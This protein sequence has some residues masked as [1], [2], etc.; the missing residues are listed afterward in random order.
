MT[1]HAILDTATHGDL[2][3][4][5]IRGETEGDAVM[6]AL[7]VPEEFRRLQDCY[8]ILFRHDPANDSFTALAIFGFEPGENL[9]LENGDW[10]ARCL[11]LAIDIQPFLIG[12]DRSGK[13]LGQV[14]IDM[15]SARISRTGQGIRVFDENGAPTPYLENIA[16]QLGA[17]DAG[18]I[19]SAE[20]FAALRYH[21]LLE[22]FT[23][24]VTL[25]DGSKNNLIGFHII[26][27]DQLRTLGAEALGELHDA[28]FLL[29]VFMAVASLTRINDLVDRKNRRQG[30]G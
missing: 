26:N 20:F 21:N 7:A 22:P 17:L 14:H 15:A 23:L 9:F 6:S 11:P 4:S 3:I 5:S 13:G 27:E 1:Q 10:Q 29:P 28:G 19:E 30:N 2:R 24:E 25:K 8:P 12:R 16:E 18:F